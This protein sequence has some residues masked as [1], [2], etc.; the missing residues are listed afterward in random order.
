[1]GF[2]VD[3]V[4]YAVAIESVREI[5]NP[6]PIVPLPHSPPA[7]LG[8][9]DHRGEAIPIVDL[10]IRLGLPTAAPTRRTKWILVVAKK[11]PVGLVVDGVTE[12][13]GP[14]E[15]AARAV[16]EIGLGD[17]ARGLSAVFG[18]EGGLTYVIDV[19][20]MTAGAGSVA[21]LSEGT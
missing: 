5:I 20:R 3:S 6:I 19:P 1:V 2:V 8:L 7:V 15:D 21:T 9:A 10:R 11:G 17:R 18:R 16:P 4:H 14:G 12:V 13:F